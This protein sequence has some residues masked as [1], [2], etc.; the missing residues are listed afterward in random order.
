MPTLPS[1]KIVSLE[2]LTLTLSLLPSLFKQ[3][4]KSLLLHVPLA[5][6]II[7]AFLVSCVPYQGVDKYI[8]QS[9]SSLPEAK[10][11]SQ[12]SP[13][14][15]PAPASLLAEKIKS[16]VGSTIFTLPFALLIFILLTSISPISSIPV[17]SELTDNKLLE[18]AATGNGIFI[19]GAELG[20]ISS[21]I[22]VIDSFQILLVPP[23]V[24]LPFK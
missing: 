18:F 11:I 14:L 1:F 24:D 22:N 20:V 21:I 16:D 15:L 3:N 23:A 5:S 19:L 9:L 17:P 6:A 10:S 2:S 12:I 7:A 13:K 4:F 8:I